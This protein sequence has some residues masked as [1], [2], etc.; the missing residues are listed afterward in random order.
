V[1]A[2]RSSASATRSSPGAC[3]VAPASTDR[4]RP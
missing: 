3:S 4:Q 2:A 1:R